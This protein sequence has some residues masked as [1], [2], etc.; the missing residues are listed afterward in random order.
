LRLTK[1]YKDRR[2]FTLIELLVVIAII[3][4]LAV[5][6]V[7]ALFKN[8][9]KA[10]ISKLELDYNGIKSALLT[11]YVDKG[12]L[13]NKDLSL[14]NP[15]ISGYIED[16]NNESPVG[17][18]YKVIPNINIGDDEILGVVGKNGEEI[19]DIP[20]S[21]VNEKFKSIL[22]VTNLKGSQE[23]ADY[24]RLTEEQFIKLSKDIGDGK[25]YVDGPGT[26]SDNRTI[27][28]LGLIS[29]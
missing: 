22:M 29:N 13:P 27:I 19:T 24:P 21:E 10:K 5:L 12:E 8:I 14:S 9:N 17:G 3:G 16:I 4:I 11:Y 25:V 1:S 2:G 15:I 7:P 23:D 26:F 18:E 28:Y 6:A 20:V